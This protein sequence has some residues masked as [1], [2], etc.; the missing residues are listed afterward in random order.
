AVPSS[1]IVRLLLFCLLA[2]G[3][4]GMHS[5]VS[6]AQHHHAVDTPIVGVGSSVAAGAADLTVAAEVAS[7]AGQGSAQLHLCLA[8]VSAIGAL[9]V[10]FLLLRTTVPVASVAA[11]C[12]R[13]SIHTALLARPPSSG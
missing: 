8:I 6:T 12:R 1:R 4:L 9:L 13:R 3:I 7:P 2:L 5:V 10:L 11:L